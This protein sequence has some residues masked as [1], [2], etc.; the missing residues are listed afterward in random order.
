MIRSGTQVVT[1]VGME[2][3]EG[4][5]IDLRGGLDTQAFLAIGDSVEIML[6][7]CHVRTLRDQAEAALGDIA[8]IEAAEDLLGN[9]YH[10]GA[11]ALTAAALAREKAE[12]ARTAGAGV[13]AELTEQA[14]TRAA[15]AAA[16]AQ[17]AANVAAE[18]MHRVDEA[19]E[20][21]RAAA[22]LATRAASEQPPD[23]AG[24]PVRLV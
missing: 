1:S 5:S 13:R 8:R 7:E 6:R 9:A 23:D 20:E 24:R 18:A 19:A 17:S 14:A 15:E 4:V 22:I 10:A 3:D 11:Q 16:R 12:A 21:A 2:L